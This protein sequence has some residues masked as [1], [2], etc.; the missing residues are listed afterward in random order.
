MHIPE[1]K[2]KIIGGIFFSAFSLALYFFIIPSQIKLV[3]FHT[4]ISPR[5]FPTILSFVLLIFSSSLA[6][7]G[8]MDRKK[9]NQKIYTFEAKEVKFVI[10]TLCIITLQT[11]GFTTIGYLVPSCLA[12]AALMYMYGQRNY[13]IILLIA[14]LLPLGIKLFFENTIQVYLP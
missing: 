2:A 10:A 14:I 1:Y 4:T 6:I 8:Y 5:Y 3:D 9:E 11:I 13:I 7:E 12:L